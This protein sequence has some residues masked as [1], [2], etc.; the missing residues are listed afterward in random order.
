[1]GRLGQDLGADNSVTFRLMMW[2]SALQIFQDNPVVGSGIGSFK[3]LYPGV[4]SLLETGT[5]GNFVHNDYLQLLA[6]G[7][8]LM[9][10]LLAIFALWTVVSI[11]NLAI[12]GECNSAKNLKSCPEVCEGI[13]CCLAILAV[14]IHAF[15][16]FIFYVAPISIMLGIYIGRILLIRY[17]PPT[18]SRP[19][20]TPLQFCA[21]AICGIGFSYAALIAA[22]SAASAAWF[23]SDN[24]VER[25]FRLGS[26]KYQ[27]A[28]AISYLNPMD[29]LAL[30]FLAQAATR[31][32]ILHRGT[33]LGASIAKIAERD[34]N[35]LFETTS[36][37]CAARTNQATLAYEFG[38]EID[39]GA[40]REKNAEA[41]LRLAIARNPTCLAPYMLLSEIYSEAGSIK[42]AAAV[43][44]QAV[45]WFGHPGA[46]RGLRIRLAGRLA[47]L[48]LQLGNREAASRTAMFI[49]ANDADNELAAK[50]LSGS[51]QF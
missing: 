21:K 31:E 19:S 10:V 15:V 29:Y 8:P 5:S 35:R 23:T 28:L 32:A 4:R 37:D 12:S 22:T 18:C 17:P 34:L 51:A 2:E 42:D 11:K 26:E 9:V 6:E 46:D 1:L 7:G 20:R 47:S 49:L 13:G 45:L 38:S 48:Q 30:R 44:S 40:M 14:M 25:D 33:E 43:L 3:L 36:V 27:R 16:N 41:L 24:T 39:G 50:I